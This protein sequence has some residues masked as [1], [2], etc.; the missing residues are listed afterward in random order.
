MPSPALAFFTMI[1]NP[2][3][4]SACSAVNAVM[5]LS[6]PSGLKSARMSA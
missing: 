3:T 2:V 6:V 1:L 5:G 4:I